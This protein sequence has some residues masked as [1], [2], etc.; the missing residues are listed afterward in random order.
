MADRLALVFSGGGAKGAFGAG[1]LAEL[2]KRY[3]GLRYDIVSGTSTGGLIAPFASL[4]RHDTAYVD[5]LRRLYLTSSQDDIV[6]DNLSGFGI[7]QAFFDLPEGIY[8]HDPLRDR[9]DGALSAADRAALVSSDVV[10]ILNAVNLQSGALALWVQKRHR[11]AIRRWFDTHHATGDL[12]VEFLP[13]PNLT[14]A[15]VATAAIPAAIDPLQRGR[16]QYV[17]GG[18]VDLAPLRAA[19]A[20]GATHVLTVF[21]SPRTG[22]PS[23]GVRENLL[24]VALRAVDLLTEEIGR[25]DVEVARRTTDL[26]AL[27]ATL[28]ADR[29][30]LPPDTAAWVADNLTLLEKLEK[31]RAIDVHVVEPAIPLGETLDFDS[32]VQPGW[33][34][35]A[36]PGRRIGIMHARYRYGRRHLREAV[37][38]DTALDAMLRSFT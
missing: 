8:S 36:R 22:P 2:H 26:R 33:P 3:P 17:D 19:V 30:S 32:K 10:T 5:R 34:E 9:I 24:E 14:D 28:L 15:M 20:A 23:P 4:A 37:S 29:G 21:M 6:E 38:A 16:T 11:R 12:S 1:V 18:V 13:E 31:R 7:I 35:D 27:A 25:N